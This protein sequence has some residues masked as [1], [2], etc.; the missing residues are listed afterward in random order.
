MTVNAGHVAAVKR[1]LAK[2]P[3]AIWAQALHPSLVQSV[4]SSPALKLVSLPKV[5]REGL[6]AVVGGFN[7]RF[8][9]FVLQTASGDALSAGLA[10]GELADQLPL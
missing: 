3:T 8:A 4:A 5:V 1:A 10:D 9:G 7:E 6:A 2:H